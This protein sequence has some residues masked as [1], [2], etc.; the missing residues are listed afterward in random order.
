MGFRKTIQSLYHANPARHS[1]AQLDKDEKKE[2][3]FT[4][5]AI[6]D[7]ERAKTDIETAAVDPDNEDDTEIAALPRTVRQIVSLEDN[8]ELPTITFRYFVLSV[9]FVIPGAFLSQMSYF[10]TT[11]AP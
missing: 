10:R 1:V 3:V 9:I 6:G 8:P 5:Q 11:Q 4:E 7:E 2:P